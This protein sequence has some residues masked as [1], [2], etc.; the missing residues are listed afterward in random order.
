MVSCRLQTRSAS[1]AS[2]PESSSRL[3]ATVVSCRLNCPELSEHFGQKTLLDYAR[4][5]D[6]SFFLSLPLSPRD[7]AGHPHDLGG[8][9]LGSNVHSANQP[10]NAGRT[11]EESAPGVACRVK[12]DTAVSNRVPEK[13]WQNL[14]RAIV[15]DTERTAGAAFG[16][17]PKEGP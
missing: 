7:P 16:R 3:C 17:T 9:D 8:G 14:L 2:A 10:W 5:T 6:P 13:S 15:T 11:R 1:R 12:G 4:P